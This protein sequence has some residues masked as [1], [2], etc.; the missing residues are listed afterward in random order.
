[1]TVPTVSPAGDFG[2]SL[3]RA[4]RTGGLAPLIQVLS[5]LQDPALVV[6]HDTRIRYFNAA[7]AEQFGAGF[8]KIGI[9]PDEIAGRRLTDL[10]DAETAA[11]ILAVL[12]SRIPKFRVYSTAGGEMTNY[13][14]IIPL[15][16]DG[17]QGGALILH[18][19]AETLARMVQERR[20]CQALPDGPRPE[21][22]GEGSLPPSFRGV[23]GSA[24]EFLDTLRTA[25]RVAPSGAS[26]C[27]TGESGTGKE[28]IARAI[29]DSSRYSAGPL[30]AVNCAAIPGPL[31]ESELFGYEKGAFT[32]AKTTGNPGKF[33]LAHHGT[34]FL[35]EI[36]ELPLPMQAKLLQVL[37]ERKVTRLGGQ[38]PIKLDFRLITATNQDLPAMIRA[39]TFRED[40]YYRIDVIPLNIP[41]LRARK[42]DIPILVD[43]FLAELSD[44]HGRWYSLSRRALELLSDYDWPGNVRELKNCVERIAVLSGTDL[45]GAEHLPSQILRRTQSPRPCPEGYRLH[46]ILE[47]VER[48]TM[49]AAL[50]LTNGNKARAIELLGISKR[51]FYMKM[52]KYQLK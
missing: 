35:D 15:S 50:A 49:Q 40:L 45:I 10:C 11:P 30:V 52:E 27:L 19:N 8:Q 6:D 38:K 7:Y 31:L 24:P 26:V 46:T 22:D 21:P 14:D 47:Q 23:I 51:A 42:G 12:A 18:R 36:G 17:Q 37:Q 39:G 1:M 20:R 34:L 43:H 41:P 28:V 13:A 9:P 32:G 48:D 16:L 3:L 25:A 33:E 44:Q 4:S 5:M 29:H 2:D